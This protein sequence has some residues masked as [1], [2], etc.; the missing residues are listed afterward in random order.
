MDNAYDKVLQTVVTANDAAIN[1]GFEPYRF[2]CLHCG[3]EV[4]IAAPFSI[5]R[6]PHFRHL[7][8]NNDIECEKY[9][10]LGLDVLQ[11][12]GRKK[13]NKEIADIVYN[14]TTRTFSLQI[15]FTEEEINLY[16][17][18][19]IFLEIRENE[20]HGVFKRIAINH[21][22]FISDVFT[23]FILDKFS[24]KY[25]VTIDNGN[26][27]IYAFMTADH[28]SVFKLQG[29]ENDYRAKLLRS[30]VKTPVLYT[31]NRYLIVSLNPSIINQFNSVPNNIVENQFEIETM[32]RMCFYAAEITINEKNTVVEKILESLGYRLEQNDSFSVLWPP[33]KTCDDVSYCEGDAIYVMSSFNLQP[34]CGNNVNAD[35]IENL[36]GG[37]TKITLDDNIRVYRKNTELQL[38]KYIPDRKIEKAVPKVIIS[39]KYIVPEDGIT[40]LLEDNKIS[41][42]Q[43][44]QKVYLSFGKTIQRIKNNIVIEIIEPREY[45]SLSFDEIVRDA[46][47]Y[48]KCEIN[49]DINAMSTDISYCALK[50][51]KEHAGRCNSAVLR[52]IERESV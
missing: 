7:H 21:T 13:G 26:E 42:L 24:E 17:E 39:D 47:L 11:E 38:F 41:Y 2:E 32:G 28:L 25:Y 9:S 15:K 51:L 18:E 29:D 19:N 40:F 3:E 50:Y 23:P 6:S 52:L 27:H 37:V 16:E 46:E 12:H 36:G 35:S 48:Y 22:N 33:Y 49:Y 44:N 1:R 45:N 4:R 43:P 8:G 10:G 5:Y 30:F 34:H 20:K 14:S 31:N